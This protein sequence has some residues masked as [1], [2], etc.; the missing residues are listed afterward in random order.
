MLIYPLVNTANSWSV[1][2]PNASKPQE[3]SL[4]S[5]SPHSWKLF[6]L[7]WFLHP[8]SWCIFMIVLLDLV[9]VIYLYF[10]SFSLMVLHAL[11]ILI[12]FKSRFNLILSNILG[13]DN[14]ANI[15]ILQKKRNK[16]WEKL[17]NFSISTNPCMAKQGLKS[18]TFLLLFYKINAHPP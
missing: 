12:N 13:L 14:G 17:N 4:E 7:V 18:L 3:R 11:Q 15:S 1:W 9:P 2:V 5:R 6:L 16:K 8:F 10:F